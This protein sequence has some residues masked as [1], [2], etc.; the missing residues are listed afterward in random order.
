VVNAPFV[1]VSGGLQALAGDDYDAGDALRDITAGAILHTGAHLAFREAPALFRRGG[2][3]ADAEA[4]AMA[5][6]PPPPTENA[7]EPNPAPAA[8]V[9]DAVDQ[10]PEAARVG[11]WGKALA[12]T[13]DDSDVDVGR[14]VERERSPESL[15]R[16][17]ERDAEP[18]IPSLRPLPDDHPLAGDQTAVTTRGTEIP[19]RYGL[20]ELGDLETSHNDDLGV[21]D[22]YPE[23]L[24]PRARDRAGAMARNFQLENELNPKL[25]LGDVG[26]GSGAPIV[27]P[28]GVVESG[29]GRT[30]AL[31]RSA[32][33]GGAPYARYLAELKAQGLPVDGMKA[34]VLVRV[35]G[36]PMTGPA[37]SALAHEMN[38][39]VTE[40]MG[41]SEQA[42]ADARAMSSADLARL[43]GT[44]AGR[45]AFAKGFLSRVAPDQ[46]NQLVDDRGHLSQ[47][48]EAR[49][50]A[51]LV[52]RA[53]GDPKLVDALFEAADSNIRAI[54][55]ALK[56]AAPAWAA[57][58]DAVARG[59]TPV[60]LDVTEALRA[61]VDLVRAGREAGGA[62]R[63][64][65]E[66]LEQS[67]M[68]AGS[69][70]SPETEAFLRLFFRDDGFRAPRASGKVAEALTD[71]ADR[72]RAFTP[73]PDL[74]GDAPDE[75]TARALLA[76]LRSRFADVAGGGDGGFD[77]DDIRPPGRTERDGD[78]PAG[79]AV[80]EAGAPLVDAGGSGEAGDGG[81]RDEPQP[82]GDGPGEPGAEPGG[83]PSAA[84]LLGHDPEI[85]ALAAD[86]ARLAAENGVTVDTPENEN[87]AT[88]AQAVRAIQVCLEGEL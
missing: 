64:I 33:A 52:A 1:G 35:R 48:G 24:Q 73:G 70:V 58:R 51:A 27:A 13:A 8:S 2:M 57:F 66:R 29:N 67:E 3:A 39:D 76:G 68:F 45:R 26:A 60:A 63:F 32:A 7:F 11:A 9:P 50:D 87:P 10:L 43:D 84:S 78:E 61:A 55:A 16:L 77:F 6:A 46:L 40:R 79:G 17:D 42:M 71:Y 36:E 38:A 25:L 54:G 41:A 65:L 37:R 4:P 31:R 22:A 81:Q 83:E 74:F 18:T 62:A 23:E 69:E 88:V 12:D 53:Y 82:G 5:D 56:D 85:A 19:V 75:N 72:A 14:F 30:I 20:A 49:I 21:N 44:P 28:D 15:A 47:G 34:P 86:T 80:G 59:E